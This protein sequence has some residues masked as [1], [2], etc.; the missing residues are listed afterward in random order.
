MVRAAFHASDLRSVA[1]FVVLGLSHVIASD[2]GCFLPDSASTFKQAQVIMSQSL[3]KGKQGL[4][5]LM[6]GGAGTS[7]IEA[8]GAF[9]HANYAQYPNLDPFHMDPKAQ[10]HAVNMAPGPSTMSLSGLGPTTNSQGIAATSAAFVA[11]G[12]S[13][14]PTASLLTVAAGTSGKGLYMDD[15]GPP[16]P[17]EEGPLA[18]LMRIMLVISTLLCSC[19]LRAHDAFMC[20][21]RPQARFD[22]TTLCACSRLFIW[23]GISIQVE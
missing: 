6:G 18:E 4:I 9:Q 2:A 5:R 20:T 15:I 23:E 10:Q 19:L 16:P 22:A 3:Q 8:A 12:P 21:R 11:P 7:S 1:L 13:T 14:K 17:I